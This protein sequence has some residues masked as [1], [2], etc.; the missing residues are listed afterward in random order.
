MK[1]TQLPATALCIIIFF[2][3]SLSTHAQQQNWEKTS[4]AASAARQH[5]DLAQAETLYKQALDLQQKELGPVHDGLRDQKS[6][7]LATRQAADG[8]LR[9]R[10]CP[11]Q[12]DDLAHPAGTIPFAGP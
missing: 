6:L 11:H 4:T 10:R 8:A 2:F 3:T 1:L 9:I 12:F 5:G 7:L